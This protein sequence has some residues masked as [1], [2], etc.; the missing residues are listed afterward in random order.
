LQ[1][2][3]AYRKEFP[4]TDKYTFMNHAAVAPT[5]GCVVE[6][7]GELFRELSQEGITR[8]PN[9]M[10]RIEEVRGLFAGLINS[11]PGEIAFVGN[12]SEGLGA[13]ASGLDWRPGESVL[14]P[15]PEF[16]ANVYPW[17]NLQKK[18]VQVRFIKR[19]DGRFGVREVEKA[20]RPG[21]RL[22]SVSSVCF[23]TGFL[24]DLEAL[25]EFCREK[26]LLFCVDAIQSLGV[27]PMDV[28]KYNIH[29]MAAGGHKWLLGTMGCG[30]LFVSQK[31]N[32]LLHPEITGWK[33]VVDEEDFFRR[34]FDLKTDALRF[35]PGTMNLAGIYGMGAAVD[36]L[37]K[38][39]IEE[40]HEKVLAMNDQIF[41][42]LKE[43][44]LKVVTPMDQ[45]ERSGIISFL[46]SVDPGNLWKHL[47]R[48]GIMVSQRDGMIRLSPHFY[49]NGADVERFFEALDNS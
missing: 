26:G 43:R 37:V 2:F 22:L 23:A 46:P 35:E 14:V 11:N 41:Q 49:N 24:C 27:V 40:I 19:A 42:G 3:D 38:A 18:G 31:A 8:F 48:E 6:A 44:D 20:L 47:T 36:L 7:M 45:G 39:G 16:P 30:M 1:D 28:R 13:V 10:R 33:S 32:D 29:F 9:W 25:G 4:V 5:P 34:H 15:E 12:T 17:M 21:T